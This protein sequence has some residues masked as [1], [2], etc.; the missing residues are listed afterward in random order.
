MSQHI[1][2]TEVT[3]NKEKREILVMF[4]NGTLRIVKRF[5]FFPFITF[6]SSVNVCRLEELLLFSG[7][8][9][10]EL[11]N[12]VNFS[13]IS[14]SSVDE[15]KKISNCIA[16]LTEKKPV[17][18]EPERQFLLIK[19]W[20]YFDSFIVEKNNE[21]QHM[22]ENNFTLE[23]DL[24]FFLTREIPF[25]EAM[26]LNSEET[27]L[28]VEKC[29]W[30]SLLNVPL[31]KVPFTLQQKTELLLENIFF[32]N[33]KQIS[34]NKHNS[35][36]PLKDFVPWGSFS[37]F[38]E[39]DFSVVWSQLISNNFFNIGP[40]TINCACCKP[41]K[42]S[43]KNLIPSSMIEVEFNE[44]AFYFE[45]TSNTFA[46]NFHRSNYFKE[47]RKAKKKEFFLKMYPVG[48]FFKSQRARIPIND[49][50]KLL[51][52][53][54]VSLLKNHLPKWFCLKEESFLSREV[55]TITEKLFLLQK[56]SP[57][58]QES[59]FSQNNFFHW[60]YYASVR[61]LNELLGEIPFALMNPMSNF[62]LEDVASSIL[63]I[64]EATLAR[65]KE[66]S[67]KKGYR[68]LH[69]SKKTAF[70]KGFSSLGLA[71]SFSV[72]TSLPQP[73]IRAFSSNTKLVCS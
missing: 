53:K 13:K 36:F 34:W 19:R 43:D 65:F 42:L 1:Y 11:E 58:P 68:V 37:K 64:Q 46:L 56:K 40:E 39:I 23:K 47:D 28:L 22:P 4:S 62:F 49:A 12:E 24:G 15:L 6:D 5:N 14:A 31:S 55:R 66:F 48:P 25:S 71:K 70:V 10:F 18:I 73:K 54:K 26:R 9:R 63:S 8:K 57:I 52:E 27:L 30:S 20:S 2:L 17:V 33:G 38:S 35:F 44:D 41:V 60:F 50:K 3:Y 59:L 16:K 7:I 67:E 29:V 51:D 32:K 69:L 45:S 61:S 21:L 72:E